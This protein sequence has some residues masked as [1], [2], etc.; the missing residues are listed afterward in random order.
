M[1]THRYYQLYFTFEFEPNKVLNKIK[2]IH[3][4]VHSCLI[5][6]GVDILMAAAAPG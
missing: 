5:S 1:Y 4:H 2:Q 3:N 6:K